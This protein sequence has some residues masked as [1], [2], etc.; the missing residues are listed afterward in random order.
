LTSFI[1]KCCRDGHDEANW[2]VAD[3]TPAACAHSTQDTE[4]T[5]YA[6][7]NL[8]TLINNS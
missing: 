5:D 3:E 7:T 4:W 1:V 2:C 8:D 6:Q